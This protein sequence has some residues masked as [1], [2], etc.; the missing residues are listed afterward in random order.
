MKRDKQTNRPG[1]QTVPTGTS[2]APADSGPPSAPLRLS[3]L[4]LGLV[5]QFNREMADAY[6]EV[7]DDPDVGGH[8]RAAARESALLHRARAEA[9]DS[10]AQRLGACR[11]IVADPR[12]E[13][14]TWS[15]AGPERRERERRVSRRRDPWA[16]P[17]LGPGIADRRITPDRRQ[18]ERRGQADHAR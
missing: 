4:E 18:R 7:G 6:D 13:E 5:A 3:S 8:T 12:L 14:A 1:S 9:F 10:E 16:T 11:S 15:Y 17:S 2:L